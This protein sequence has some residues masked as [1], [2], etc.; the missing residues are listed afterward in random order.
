MTAPTAGPAQPD[1]WLTA[2][3]MLDQVA[4]NSHTTV[5]E[6]LDFA[7]EL[8]KGLASL[9][10]PSAESMRK[11]QAYWMMTRPGKPLPPALFGMPPSS[12]LQ[13]LQRTGGS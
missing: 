3:R 13:V 1:P 10:P 2:I 11:V 7:R 4:G 12:M 5:A 8:G 9:G 6:F